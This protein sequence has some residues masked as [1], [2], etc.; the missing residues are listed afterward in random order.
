[1]PADYLST[2]RALSLPVSPLESPVSTRRPI[3]PPWRRRSRSDVSRPKSRGFTTTLRDDALAT[4]AKIQKQ[5]LRLLKKLSWWQKILLGIVIAATAV[6]GILSIVYNERI[7]ISLEP[8][9]EKW[10]NLKAGWLIMWAL[11]FCCG[12]PPIIGYSTSVT[13]AGFVYGFPNGWFIAATATVVGSFCSFLVSKTILAGYVKRLVANDQRFAALSLMLKHDG[14]KILCMIRLCPLPYSLSNGAIATFPTVNPFAFAAATAVATPKLALHIFVGGRMAEIA[15]QGKK[16][17]LGTKVINY[18]GMILGLA[19]GLGV[20][21][22]VYQRTKARALQL[23]EEEESRLE[24]ANNGDEG[25][26]PFPPMERDEMLDPT[27]LDD[28]ISLYERESTREAYRDD[29]YDDE[30]LAG[31]NRGGDEESDGISP[32][33]TKTETQ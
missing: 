29:F 33:T 20:G 24:N 9:A 16:M 7:L 19:L 3:S 6:L 11:I 15:R 12:F 8:V 25:T 10:R 30:E 22:V 1:M 13:I 26:W 23:E 2:A 5:S 32:V 21:W 18:A 17:D 27:M 28:D 14:I 4:Y 31:S